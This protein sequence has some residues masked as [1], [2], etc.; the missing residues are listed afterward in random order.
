MTRV[1]TQ[2]RNTETQNR[3]TF[4]V[5]V[6][7][8]NNSDLPRGGDVYRSAERQ[9][10]PTPR[11]PLLHHQEECPNPDRTGSTTQKHKTQTQTQTE[12]QREN[13]RTARTRRAHGPQCSLKH[14]HKQTNGTNGSTQ[15][16]QQ[17]AASEGN[18]Q[19]YLQD[20]HLQ[21]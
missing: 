2:N 6:H 17:A 4:L 11:R 21:A 9:G 3:N 15:D 20:V 1:Q 16:G 19:A 10:A 8:R 14:K 12:T 13:T 7:V 18:P 5:V